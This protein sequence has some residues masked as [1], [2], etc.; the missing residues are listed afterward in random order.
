MRRFPEFGAD[1]SC[2]E[3]EKWGNVRWGPSRRMRWPDAVSLAG[4]AA[5]KLKV[6]GLVALVFLACVLVYWVAREYPLEVSVRR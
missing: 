6:R 5:R 3:K 1:A 2:A 4:R